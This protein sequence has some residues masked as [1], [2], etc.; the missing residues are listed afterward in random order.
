MGKRK[1]QSLKKKGVA[2][3]KVLRHYTV[4]RSYC[5]H[6]PLG[7]PPNHRFATLGKT[8]GGSSSLIRVYIIKRGN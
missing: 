3:A 8:R 2:R 6:L 4:A 5:A 1:I 7:P